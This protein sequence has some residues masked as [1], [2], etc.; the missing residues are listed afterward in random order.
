MDYVANATNLG[1]NGT[2]ME[3]FPYPAEWWLLADMGTANQNQC[4]SPA[5]GPMSTGA[6]NPRV[7]VCHNQGTN[8]GFMDGHA[9][10]KNQG[11]P[12]WSGSAGNVPASD[13]TI[14][15]L[16]ALIRHFWMGTD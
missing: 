4:N 12:L 15:S 1:N 7:G 2:A 5:C 16:T 11:D 14:T 8:V 10:W 3:K 9:Q 6:N 13:G